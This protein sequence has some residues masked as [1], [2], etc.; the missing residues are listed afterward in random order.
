MPGHQLLVPVVISGLA[1]VTRVIHNQ[2]YDAIY[3][4]LKLSYAFTM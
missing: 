4:Q 1:H 3:L 2:Q